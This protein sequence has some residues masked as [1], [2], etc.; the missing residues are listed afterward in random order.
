MPVS[1]LVAGVVANDEAALSELCRRYG[2]G[3]RWIARQRGLADHDAA[4][5][6]QDTILDSILQI[7]SGDIQNPE[8]LTGYLR[9]ICLR[10]AINFRLKNSRIDSY[11]A[12][13]VM[14]A[15]VQLRDETGDTERPAILNQRAVI[16]R[17]ALEQLKPRDRELLTRFYLDEQTQEQIMRE[18]RLTPT[19][20][21]LKKSRAKSIFGD[22]GKQLLEGSRKRLAGSLQMVP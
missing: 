2:R 16:V 9:V 18:M 4:D 3:L 22:I 5:I 11:D 13:P 14:A 10:K 19:Q 12:N 15:N 6:A 21:R 8:A 7:Q 20:F 1:Q 17:K